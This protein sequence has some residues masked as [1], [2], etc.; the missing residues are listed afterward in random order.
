MS[1][2]IKQLADIV[3]DWCEYDL[4]GFSTHP[5]AHVA[6]E[7]LRCILF[8]L[9]HDPEAQRIFNELLAESRREWIA[10]HPE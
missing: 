9:T 10:S 4:E 2:D 6:E 5:P 1:N 8:T 3:V 7:A